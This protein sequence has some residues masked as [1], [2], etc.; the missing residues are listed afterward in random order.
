MMRM[1]GGG[2]RWSGFLI[3]TFFFIIIRWRNKVCNFIFFE[4]YTRLFF[5][6]FF[7]KGPWILQ[8]V[9][10]VSFMFPLMK[11]M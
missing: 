11:K 8:T 7:F 5:H 4:N 6:I 1:K 9:V 3:K 10:F 2:I